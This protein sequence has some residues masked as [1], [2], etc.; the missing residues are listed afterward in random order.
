MLPEERRQKIVDILGL[1]GK[2][3]VPDLAERLS[4]SV[5][6]IRR[7]LKVL[8]AASKLS[9]VHG[10]ALPRSSTH[11]PYATR[12]TQNMSKK[13]VLG[14]VAADLL[15]PN[16]VIFIDGGSTTLEV[17]KNIPF[18]ME[19]TIMTVCPFVLVTLSHHAHIK[20]FMLGGRLNKT[21]MTVVGSST[22]DAL[23][24]IH[25]DVCILGIC[26]LHP[27]I[28]VTAHD[29]EEARIKAIMIQNAADVIA[30]STSEKLGSVAPFSVAALN[31][32]THI[33]TDA[34]LSDAQAAR[35]TKHGVQLIDAAKT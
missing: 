4:I 12:Q 10:G 29:Y 6:T 20:A 27:D 9:R 26:S 19:A 11:I 33:V 30:V 7:D 35:Y 25:A 14:K 1:E 17:A 15:K 16:Q 2:V 34:T 28:G 5:D 23:Q 13:K 22:S 8:E 3:T 21:S 32:L 31:T 18:D 24:S